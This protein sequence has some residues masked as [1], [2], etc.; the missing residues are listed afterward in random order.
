MYKWVKQQKI[1]NL[2]HAHYFLKDFYS[3]GKFN[4]RK[5]ANIAY[6]C[7]KTKIL[8]FNEYNPHKKVP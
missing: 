1:L 6:I 7:I 8:R 2:F 5:C 4:Y 3:N